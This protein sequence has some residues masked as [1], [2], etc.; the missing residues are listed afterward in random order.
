MKFSLIGTG[1]IMPRH[2]QSIIEVGGEIQDVVND[3]YSETAWR[4]MVKNTDA[5]CIV[6]MTP[7]DLHFD[8]SL[9]AAENRKLVL[10]EKPLV[11][12]S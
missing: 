6:I 2:A 3:A 11:I 9:A 4:D 5:D 12:K 10:C 7:N 8:M 1:F